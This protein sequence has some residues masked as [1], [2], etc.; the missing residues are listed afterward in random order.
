MKPASVIFLGVL[1]GDILNRAIAG[2]VLWF[3]VLMALLI[4]LGLLGVRK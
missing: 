4:A 2:D 3:E 1:L